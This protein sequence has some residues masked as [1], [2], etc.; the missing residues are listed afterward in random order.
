M[1]E[2]YHSKKEQTR[3][4]KRQKKKIERWRRKR[5]V[6]ELNMDDI[7]Y[8]SEWEALKRYYQYNHFKKKKI[9]GWKRHKKNIERW[10]QNVI[11]L[12]MNYFFR[13][14]NKLN[15]ERRIKSAF[16]GDYHYIPSV[17]TTPPN[18]YK[19]TWLSEMIDVYLSWYEKMAKESDDFYLKIWIFEPQFIES[20]IFASFKYKETLL[21]EPRYPKSPVTKI[22]PFHKFE[23]LKD[24]LALFDWE[25][26]INDKNY[27]EGDLNRYIQYGVLT[28][29]EVNEIRNK[30]YE[31]EKNQK[32]WE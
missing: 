28:E 2:F 32:I 13:V 15:R 30:C 16:L 27:W 6:I 20:R 19:R 12:D 10:R 18:W 3:K 8:L 9:R 29:A 23:S 21:N 5:N 7:R 31:T 25:A 4:W 22:F 1:K 24:K 17:L 11:N 26:H 14:R